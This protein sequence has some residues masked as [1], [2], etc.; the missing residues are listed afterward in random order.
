MTCPC[1][2]AVPLD[3]SDRN[4]EQA[5]LALRII[6]RLGEYIPVKIG[7]GR[8]YRVSRHC[9]ALHGIK[10]AEIDTYGFEELP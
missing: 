10:A 5:A 9:I 3:Y 7:N 6:E 1:R 2:R 4:P 8:T